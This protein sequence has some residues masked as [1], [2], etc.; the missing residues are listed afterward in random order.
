MRKFLLLSF[1]FLFLFFLPQG[2]STQLG[3]K[4]IS[5]AISSNYN[6]NLQIQ[7]AEISWFHSTRLKNIELKHEEISATIDQIII[8]GNLFTLLA[9]QA[10]EIKIENILS[11]NSSVNFSCD[12]QYIESEIKLKALLNFDNGIVEITGIGPKNHIDFFVQ[13]DLINGSGIGYFEKNEFGIKVPFHGEV[14][15][16]DQNYQVFLLPFSYHLSSGFTSLFSYRIL[17][18]NQLQLTGDLNLESQLFSTQF[19]GE[20]ENEPLSGAFSIDRSYKLNFAL[21]HLPLSFFSN[22]LKD[23]SKLKPI[24]GPSLS[25]KLDG[26]NENFHCKL[27]TEKFQ[28]S[29]DFSYLGDLKFKSSSEP[30]AFSLSIDKESFEAVQ[31]LHHGYA[32]KSLHLLNPALMQGSLS[33]F[34]KQMKSK[35]KL[36]PL[37]LEFEGKPFTIQS[38]K[39]SLDNELTLNIKGD[40]DSEELRGAFFLETGN[41]LTQI[42][43]KAQ[44]LPTV[45]LDA[46]FSLFGQEKIISEF[47]LGDFFSIA[48]NSNDQD[49]YLKLFSPYFQTCI[50]GRILEKNLLLNSPSEISFTPTPLALHSLSKNFNIDFIPPKT[51]IKLHID[52]N[53]FR[54]PLFPIDLTKLEVPNFTFDI[55][56]LFLANIK[57]SFDIKNLFKFTASKENTE[58]WSTPLIG[59]I[60]NGQI[61]IDRTEVLLD[62]ALQLALWGKVNFEKKSI[63]MTLGLTAES[64]EREFQILDL[65]PSYVLKIPLKGAFK[66]IRFDT[67]KAA[68]KIAF[69]IG[70]NQA[71][72]HLGIWG[73]LLVDIGELFDDQS[74]VPPP[75]FFLPWEKTFDK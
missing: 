12:I 53:G 64:L 44:S 27:D 5:R 55:N 54:F 43:F 46:A 4:L 19:Q 25:V 26:N 52:S 72:N 13:S 32:S 60:H 23:F 47:F 15:L 61:D 41:Q 65:A 33:F 21:N 16:F 51:P 39:G 3:L 42:D 6:I 48:L 71:H 11:N 70:R 7:N 1:S 14:P 38:L 45:A 75:P 49:L 58:I 2:L 17:G 18:P 29:G 63:D 56:R 74:D 8:G 24:F 50:E 28:F 59:H 37:I 20:F 10:R 73:D 31:L 36:Q 57:K 67:K 30:G 69:L 34:Q 62:R 40:I 35:W 9:K 66:K 22:Y 68:S